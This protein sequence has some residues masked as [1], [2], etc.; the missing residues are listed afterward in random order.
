[1]KNPIST[2]IA[3]IL[4]L[5]TGPLSGANTESKGNDPDFVR[6]AALKIDTY[7]AGWYRQKKLPVPDVTDD[8][9]F[10]RRA[11][12]VGIGRVPTAEEGLF[13]LEM[14]DPN[15]RVE[16]I[17]YLINSPGYT[18]HMTN[19]MFDLLRIK[20]EMA[21]VNSGR[22][23]Y[24]DW[25]GNFV[26]ANKPW[27]EL[28]TELLASKG[29]LWADG[30]AAVGYYL[31]DQGMPLDNLANSMQ[32]F[33]GTQMECAQCHD[34]PFGDTERHDFYELAAFTEGQNP[35]PMERKARPLYEEARLDK[36][37]GTAKSDIIELVRY[38]ILEQTLMGGGSGRISLPKDYQYRDAQP[39]EVIGGRTPFG[40]TVRTSD[41]GVD[42]DGRAKLAE[43]VTTK[44]DGQFQAVMANRLWKKIMGRGIYEPINEYVAAKD[45]NIPGLM[46]YIS[47]LLV[48]VDYDLQAFQKILLNTKTFQFVPNPNPAKVQNGDDF[49]G[50][51]L[52]RLSAE[53]IWDSLITLAG[54]NPDSKPRRTL[55]NRVRI[56][57]NGGGAV[58]PGMTMSDLS[59]EVLKLKTVAELDAYC[60]ELA[61]MVGGK[62]KKRGGDSMMMMSEEIRDYG[63][64]AQVRASELP[65]PAPN[66]HLLFLF[67]QST[68]DTVNGANSEPNVSQVLTLM[69]G[70]VQD[71]LVNNSSAHIYKSLDGAS[72]PTEKVR[73]LYVGILSR[74][75]S[76][77][78]MSWMMDEVKI[79]GDTDDAYRNILSALV[80]S[81]EFLF[82][83]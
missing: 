11:F 18:S 29:S 15:K 36:N 10:L 55:D 83:Q 4:L 49:H 33:L 31:R 17:D 7:V 30:Q 43:W 44:T 61:A 8:A 51:Q 70:F 53:Q 6:Q 1:M 38:Q 28:T 20:D 67:G 77:E 35:V 62:G 50:R 39:G 65:S 12:L 80:M 9:T 54:G 58:I 2:C 25:V 69:N 75:P 72:S 73:R 66:G 81:S 52:T 40:K 79:S 32:I 63:K 42:G 45:T 16:L 26:A 23:P 82:L 34:D 27:D 78:E 74:P 47:N 57:R 46:S 41:R 14:D 21:R 60:G 68:R 76:D 3:S 59:D 19:W 56:G 37:R 48:E 71:Q 22:N 5:A 24:R 13:F 64:G